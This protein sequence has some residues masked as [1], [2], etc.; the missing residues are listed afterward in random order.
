MK[1]GVV[2]VN[3]N[4]GDLTLA[5]LKSLYTADRQPWRILVVD[6]ASEDGSPQTIAERFPGV[7]VLRETQNTGFAK[8]NN[9]GTRK[10]MDQGADAIWVL[11]NDTEVAADCLSALQ[12]GLAQDAGAGV[13]TGKILRHDDPGVIWYAG[14]R[15]NR[16]TLTTAHR[17]LGERDRGQYDREGKTAF[18]SGCCM[19]IR[20]ETLERVGLFNETYFAYCEDA[21]WCIRALAAGETLRYVPRATLTHKVSASVHKNA[22]K[23]KRGTVAPL[24]HYL[25]ARN[26]LFTLRLHAHRPSQIL[27]GYGWYCGFS[28]WIIAGHLLKGRWAKL[29]GRIRGIR[30]GLG[31]IPEAK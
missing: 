4:G 25:N 8:A 2:L 3:W 21:E 28:L 1:V 14:G 23:E 29:S 17:G 6:N 11:N 31:M 18:V 20:R 26:R 13:V 9:T 7:T 10:L 15:L 16:L 5:C 12:D 24:V 30:D 19:L 27:A 22:F